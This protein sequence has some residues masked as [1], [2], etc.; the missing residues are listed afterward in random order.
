MRVILVAAATL[1]LFG[2]TASDAFEIKFDW[3]GLKSCTNGDPNSVPS[4]EFALTDVP[5]GTKFIKFKLVDKDVPGYNHGGGTVS[6]SGEGEISAGAFTY[7]SPCPPNGSHKYEW[8]ATAQSK[9][10]GGVLGK[11]KATRMYPE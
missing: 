2:T 4:P 9:K 6:W 3:A 1:F 5:E 8:T 10:S 11:A 7:K